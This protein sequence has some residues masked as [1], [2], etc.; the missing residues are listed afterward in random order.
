MI[1]IQDKYDRPKAVLAGLNVGERPDRYAASIEELRRLAEAC[2]LQ[3]V[4]R[5][6]QNAASI[7]QKTLLGRGKVEELKAAVLAAD[8]DIVIFQETLTPMQVRNLEDILDTEVLDRTGV[9]LQIFSTRA[10]TREAR[11]QVKSAQLQYVLPRLAGMRKNLSRQGGGSGRLSN[12][13]AGEEQL[14]L[15]R[16]HI[17]RQLAEIRRQLREV[18]KERDTQRSRRVRSGLPLI[19]LV[20]YTNAGK[21]TLMNG[22]LS[23]NEG[24]Y[25]QSGDHSVGQSGSRNHA[26]ESTEKSKKVFEKDM[27]FATLDTAVRRIEIP[28]HRPF[29]LSD[30][31]GFISDLPHTLVDAFR[32]TLE[33]ACYADL[34]IEVV[35]FSD[36]EYQQQLN[37]TRK[38][39]EEIGA[40][41]VPVL[42]LYNKTD[43]CEIPPV[44]HVFRDHV[45]FAARDL[46][47]Y[48]EL[49]VLLDEILDGKKEHHTYLLPYSE[50]GLV[51]E[52]QAKYTADRLD[53]LQEGILIE[54]TLGEKDAG[55]LAGFIAEQ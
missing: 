49:L 32:S 21:S 54:L 6:V 2:G 22:F 13:G 19:S 42:V 4:D 45:Y 15:D 1:E 26:Q 41:D 53:Y 31:V 40:A 52:L 5:V 10:R 55:R 17:E 39:L 48:E 35:D 7:T 9:I 12:K 51:H 20:G 36:P 18:E 23:L 28:G 11:L 43:R 29:L 8:A 3:V 46:S 44:Q 47:R 25:D 27:L 50:G 30:T 33:E 37:V 24:E 34:L 14:E 16:R 38:T